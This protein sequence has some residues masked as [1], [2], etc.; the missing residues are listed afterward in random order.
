MIKPDPIILYNTFIGAM[1][2]AAVM[3]F[4]ALYFVKAGYG[5]F[6]AKQWGRTISNRTA[7]VVMEAPIC[8]LMIVFWLCSKR[9]FSPAPLAICLLFELHYVQRTFIFP[10]LMRG[11]GKMSLAVMSMGFF[12]NVA[13]AFMQGYWI[14]FLS[15]DDLYTP[16]WLM[17]PKF[18]I[19]TLLFLLGFVINIDSDRRIRHLRTPGDTSYYLPHGGMY[20]YVTSANYFGELIEW[21]GFAILTW[22]VPG[23]VFFIWTFANLVPRSDA[24]YKF[25]KEKFPIEMQGK[26]LKRIFP[27]IY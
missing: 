9:T 20:D 6:N 13:N 26:N 1:T 19:G 21:L 27:F 23:L 16:S 14:F 2:G 4:I 8:L 17:N 11:K 10:F 24:I 7:W 3:V 12:F 15:P 5:K 22:S 18:I 25:Y